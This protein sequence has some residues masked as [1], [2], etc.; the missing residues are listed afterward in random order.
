VGRWRPGQDSRTVDP[1]SASQNIPPGA[2]RRLTEDGL[3]IYE[4]TAEGLARL[5]RDETRP[6][7]RREAFEY[8]QRLRRDGAL[9]DADWEAL[10]RGYPE[11]ALYVGFAALNE[12]DL[13]GFLGVIAEDVEFTSMVAEAEGTTFRGHDG[14]RQWWRTVRGAF[15]D[16][17]WELLDVSDFGDRGIAH[18][19][20]AGTLGGVP[21][22]QTMWQVVKHRDGKARSWRFFRT[23]SEAEK[24]VEEER[25]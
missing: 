13:D 2:F 7:Q 3:E 25:P 19:R 8:V 4:P 24:A 12:G 18:F 20:M 14:V 9:G 10:I 23:E 5:L 22:E 1:V 6:R 15:Q 21:V 17:R 11:L 16:V